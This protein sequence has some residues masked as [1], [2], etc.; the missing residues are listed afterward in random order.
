[1]TREPELRFASAEAKRRAVRSMFDR[2][3]PRYEVA[4]RAMTFGLDGG[5]RRRLLQ[6]M[7]LGPDDTVLDLA[8]G[9]GDFVRLLAQRGLEPVG[10]DLSSGMLAH[11]PARFGR[12]QGA[13]EALPFRDACFDAVVTGFAVRN[14]ASLEAVVAEVARVLRPGGAFGILEVATPPWRVARAVHRVYF[15]RVAPVIGWAVGHDRAA[16]RYLPASVAFLPSVPELARLLVRHGFLPPRRA[17]LGLG[18]AQVVVTRR[19]RV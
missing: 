10:L 2:V 8:C 19:R 18:A 11:V 7:Q 15:H 3:A 9:T 17:L 12:V 13:G 5:W 1:M 4:N 6:E 14:F 16:Y